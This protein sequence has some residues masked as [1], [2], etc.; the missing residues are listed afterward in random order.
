MSNDCC[1]SGEKKRVVL[2]CSGASNLGQVSNGL[3]TRLQVTGKA[4]MSCLT[5]VAADL[6]N[7]IKEARQSDELI[8]LDGCSV[9]CARKVIEAKG[10]N[11][12]RYFDISDLLPDIK[13]EKR[14]DQ[15]EEGIESLWERFCQVL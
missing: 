7:Y 5:G 1:S 6:P 9:A 2:A 14:Y 13:K 4:T 3:A 8:V 15:V 10:I 11:D 12:Y